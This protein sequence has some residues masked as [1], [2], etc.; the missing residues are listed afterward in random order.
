MRKPSLTLY[1]Y[2]IA[3]ILILFGLMLSPVPEMP[4]LFITLITHPATLILDTIELAGGVSFI[5]SGLLLLISMALMGKHYRS[6]YTGIEVGALFLMA[7]F[8]FI[9][10]NIINI[11]PIIL[12][13][14]LF[15]KASRI[16]FR[17]I[18]PQALF[19]TSLCPIITDLMINTSTHPAVS[20][21]AALIVG[22][23]IGFLT[24]PVSRYT[25]KIHQGFSLYN[26]GMATG[27]IGTVYVAL[28]RSFGHAIETQLIWGASRQNYVVAFILILALLTVVFAFWFNPPKMMD[29]MKLN[30]LP[31]KGGADY[32]S[33]VNTGTALLNMA[34]LLLLSSL[35]VTAVGSVFNGGTLCG[36]LTVMGFGA[37]GKNPRNTLPILVGIYLGSLGKIWAM[38]EPKMI[39]VSLFAT[40]LAPF[41]QHFGFSAGVISGFVVSSVSISITLLHSGANL[42][43]TGFS[44]GVVAITLLPIFET[45]RELKHPSNKKMRH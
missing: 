5:N 20:L 37:N 10:K 7:S 42:Y 45:I 29:L 11:W 33:Q 41:T 13:S 43:N 22:I 32:I 16:A 4:H 18:I 2:L 40:S 39:L 21:F 8:A 17:T 44:A 12:G 35:F 3:A 34:I 27:L 14:Y 25:A 26:V 1:F 24:I 6:T 30:A 15:A 23:M 38:N 36:I 31:N 28:S 19:A 9:G